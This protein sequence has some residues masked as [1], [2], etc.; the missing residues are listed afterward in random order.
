MHDR[1]RNAEAGGRNEV[2]GA[3]DIVMAVHHVVVAVSKRL[4]ECPHEVELAI[5]L[6]RG[7]DD[8][9]PELSGSLIESAGARENTIECPVHR[10]AERVRGLE[11]PKQPALDGS[12]IETLDDVNYARR[13]WRASV[14]R[15]DGDAGM[16]P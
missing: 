15:H 5:E 7:V 1:S 8:H 14:L 6:H 16:N 13:A 2:D 10:L 9:G 3:D 12:D 11:H 4:P